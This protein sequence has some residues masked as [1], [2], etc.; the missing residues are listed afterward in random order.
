MDFVE[1][2]KIISSA[3]SDLGLNEYE[4][5]YKEGA[6]TSVDTLNREINAY[7][8][9]FYRGVCLRVIK[10]KK[11]GYASTE[12]MEEE[13]LRSLVKRALDNAMATEREDSLGI[14]PGDEK[15][16]NHEKKEFSPLDSSELR[17]ISTELA[18]SGYEAS[19]KVTDGTES[20][21]GTS[22]FTVKISNSSGLSLE[23]SSGISYLNLSAVVNDGEERESGYEICEYHSEGD[24]KKTAE[25]AVDIALSKLGATEI[26]SGK[27]N[28][29]ID[30]KR[31]RQLL[32]AFVSVFSAKS[33]QLGLSLF[34]GKEGQEIASDIVTITDDPK[35]EG[36]SITT[37]FDAE[38]VPTYRKKVVENGILKTLLYNRESAEK[39]GRE[40]TGNG[41]K[42]SYASP[43][44][45]GPYAFCIEAGVKTKEEL[46]RMAGEGILITSLSGIHAGANSVTG[47]FSLESAGFMIR[48]G[49]ICEP[50]KSFTVSGNFFKLLKKIA[51][52]SDTVEIGISG[53]YTTF[54]S[55]YVLVP[56]MSVAGD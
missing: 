25:S 24:I 1:I 47:D 51:A 29:V 31:M 39:A 14:Y 21:A 5:Y 36:V 35:R 28:L 26:K 55:P 48:E 8:S 42:A 4:I 27:Y 3:A 44:G 11:T 12:L 9:G 40:S 23:N 2:K 41:M 20:S 16:E 10:D 45:T 54:G 15:Y 46:F 37:P 19:D 22:S 18:K 50:V 43:V 13:E 34:K 52:L 6:D 17:R 56:D 30:P 32:S 7:S 53:S 33:A 38:G 49:K